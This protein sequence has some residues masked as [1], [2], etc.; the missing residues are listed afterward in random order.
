M[1]IAIP[2]TGEQ[3]V[4]GHAGQARNWLVYDCIPGSP[5]PAPNAIMLA[6]EQ[7]LHHFEDDGPHPLDGVEVVIAASAGDGLVRH[8][9]KRGAEVLLT[10]EQQPDAALARILAGEALPDPRFDITTT[11]CKLRDLFSRH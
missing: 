4:A 6:R 5:L 3:L 9:A 11:L 1:K 2:V 8:M 7:V 10:G